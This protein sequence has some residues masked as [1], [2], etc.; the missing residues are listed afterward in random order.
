MLILSKNKNEDLI[1]NN[2]DLIQNNEDLKIALSRKF[3]NSIKENLFKDRFQKKFVI[4]NIPG[5][6]IESI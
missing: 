4:I 5:E 3:D 6:P 2:E 1:E